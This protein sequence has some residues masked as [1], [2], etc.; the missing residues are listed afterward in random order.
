LIPYRRSPSNTIPSCPYIGL[1]V[2]DPRKGISFSADA[3]IDT[4]ADFSCV[5]QGALPKTTLYYDR[6][7]ATDFAGQELVVDV[8]VILD[9]TIHLLDDRNEVIA[10]LHNI[11]LRMPVISGDEALVGRD[12]LNKLTL[13]L[14]GPKQNFEIAL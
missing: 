2:V 5:P 9:A 7:I 13:M 8:A 14:D 6:Q 3:C 12:I 10:S 4:G 1:K 11:D